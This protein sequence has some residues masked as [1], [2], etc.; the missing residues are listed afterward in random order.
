MSLRSL[1]APLRSGATVRAGVFLVV[2]GLVAGAYGL[3]I[4]GFVQM[5]A[6]PQT[7]TPTTAALAVVATTLAAA[8]PFL[9]PVRT[10]EVL[11]ARTLLDVDVQTP[12]DRPS[13]TARWRGAAWFTL[14]L[15]LGLVVVVSLLVVVPLVLDLL[16]S[17]FG[18]RPFLEPGWLPAWLAHPP[19]RLLLALL[20]LVAL[21]YV[22]VGARAVLRSAAPVLLGPDQS[23]RIAELEAQTARLVA[24]NRLAQDVHDGVGHALTITVLQAAA[25]A[26]TLESDPAAARR[27][28]A[29][30][31]E[32]GRHAMAE[33]DDLLRRL[34]NPG[35]APAPGR[36]RSLEHDDL[37]TLVERA[38]QAGAD[39]TL[40]LVGDVARAPDEVVREVY[41]V[42]QESLTNALRHAPGAPVTV[43]VVRATDLGIEVRNPWSPGRGAPEER[44]GHGLAGMRERVTALGGTL[45]AGPDGGAWVVRASWP[46]VEDEPESRVATS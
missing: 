21:P 9:A 3:L 25:A 5:F 26:R 22:V 24:R 38:R 15:V 36:E 19:L 30:I 35:S 16:L 28:L 27:S 4:E 33:L 40:V 17:L 18:T 1:V 2:G 11:A 23:E 44:R 29:A 32:T 46:V 14:H 42:A 41:R 10:V 6:D 13:P 39:V 8:P 20:V 12:S 45:V 37:T 43:R 7:A 34:R 31:E